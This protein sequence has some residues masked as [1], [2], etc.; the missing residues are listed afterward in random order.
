MIQIKHRWQ[1]ITIGIIASIVV[2]VIL[3]TIGGFF[4]LKPLVTKKIQQSILNATD[5]LYAI[6]F[7]NIRYNPSI[8]HIVVS[9]VHLIPDTTVYNQLHTSQKAPDDLYKVD[10]PTIRITG[11]FPLSLFTNKTLNLDKISLLNSKV[12]IIHKKRDYNEGLDDKERKTLYQLLSKFVKTLRINKISLSDVDFTYENNQHTVTKKS[13]IQHLYIDVDDILI[14]SLSG[15]SPERVY[16]AQDYTF[17]LKQIVLPD[18]NQ[19]SDT[20]IKDIVFSLKK[21]VLTVNQ[22]HIQPKYGEMAFGK[23]SGGRDRTEVIFNDIVIKN[24]D[25]DKLFP[26]MKLYAHTLSLNGG[27]VK[28]F[29]DKRY[30]RKKRNKLGEYP[31]QLLRKLDF[32]LNIDTVLV[33]NVKVSYAEFDPDLKLTGEITF[34]RIKGELLNVTNDTIPLQKTPICRAKFH[35][36]FMN[37]GSLNVYFGLNTASKKGDFTCEGQ[38]SDFDGRAIN[39]ITI[40]L[41]KVDVKS[42]HVN[43]YTFKIKADDN[44]VTGTGLL[45]YD[46]LVA[47]LLKEDDEEGGKSLK[48]RALPS[49]LINSLVLKDSNPSKKNQLRTGTINYKREP[50]KSFFG[51]IWSGLSQSLIQCVIGNKKD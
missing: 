33:N 26:D 37:K 9:D 47:N 48:K 3:L 21:R 31:H 18:K 16:Y 11:V 6:S 35:T 7:S 22:V 20:K 43:K 25:R 10:I 34:D 24:I 44:L 49:F 17:T 46:N 30:P 19:L 42:L 2:I 32:K 13:L 1:K 5:S 51:V 29:N 38:L 28:V 40:A 15:Q 4:F 39:K 50:T 27:I 12:T 8:G 41:T 23:A 14:D 36:Y 45:L